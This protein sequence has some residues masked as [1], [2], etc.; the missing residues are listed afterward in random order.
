MEP[1]LSDRSAL[2]LGHDSTRLRS[3]TVW[4]TPCGPSFQEGA[5]LVLFGEHYLRHAICEYTE[6]YHIE[7]NHQG[8]KNRLIL[9]DLRIDNRRGEIGCHERLDGMLK[10]YDRKAV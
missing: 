10:F 1:S 4:V 9:A 3:L 7:R 5:R 2:P 6:Q 8:L